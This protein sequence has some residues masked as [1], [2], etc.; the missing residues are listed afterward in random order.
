MVLRASDAI[1]A[2]NLAIIRRNVEK[3]REF[4]NKCVR[5]CFGSR[6]PL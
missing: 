3:L 4:M 5:C 2:K 6:G 1:L